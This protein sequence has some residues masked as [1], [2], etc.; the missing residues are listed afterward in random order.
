MQ[1]H[2]DTHSSFRFSFGSRSASAP[3]DRVEH[4]RV[5]AVDASA[6]PE[7]LVAVDDAAAPLDYILGTLQDLS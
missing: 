3:Q 2:F 4:G 5:D 7:S 1:S 6:A